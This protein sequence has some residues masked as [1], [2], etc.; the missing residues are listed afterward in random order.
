MLSQLVRWLCGCYTIT[1]LLLCAKSLLL[2][3]KIDSTKIHQVDC[4]CSFFCFSRGGDESVSSS[5]CL[6]LKNPIQ[7]YFSLTL[8]K[9]A[10]SLC[11][12][13]PSLGLGGFLNT[14]MGWLKTQM[15]KD[16]HGRNKELWI[17]F[18]F[19]AKFET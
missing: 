17:Y 6:I 2:S 5:G 14:H 1:F 13:C 9:K 12:Q 10:N 18:Q 4:P 3:H 19:L 8:C 16:F 7:P 15:G 11:E